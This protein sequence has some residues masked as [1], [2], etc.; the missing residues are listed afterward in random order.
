M[1][2]EAALEL[3]RRRRARQSLLA[4]TQYTK[5][6][7]QPSGHHKI[8]CDALERVERGEIDRLIIEA[9]PRH[10]KSE[11]ATRRFPAWYLGRNSSKQIITASYGKDLSTD[12]GRDVR[13]IVSSLEFQKLF[14]VQLREDVAAASKWHT[15]NGGIYNAVA[16]G[17]AVTGKGAHCLIIDDPIKNREEADSETIREKVWRWYTST[18]YT[19]LMPGGSII[20]ILTRWH[21]DDLAGR[22]LE[23]QQQGQGDKWHHIKLPAIENEHTDH[24]KALW[25]QWY[26][27]EA[28]HRIRQQLTIGNCRDWYSLYQQTPTQEQGTYFQREWFKMY[29]PDELPKDLHKYGAS[30]YAVSEGEGDFTEHGVFGLCPRMDLWV[31]DWWFAQAAADKWIESKLDLWTKHKPFAWF[32]EGGVIQKSV[33]PMLALRIRER[34]AYCRM[35]WL[36]SIHDKTIRARAFQAFAASGRVHIPNT[37]VGKRLVEQLM[38]F[39][40]G[41][42]DDAVDV[43]SLFGRAIDTT[44]PAIVQRSQPQDYDRWRSLSKRQHKEGAESWRTA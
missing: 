12:F 6:D 13:D 23:Q 18:A 30:D 37:V 10:T 29:E 14:P 4:F 7:F 22:L 36:S 27:L 42:H 40:Q 39:P 34:R 32:G 21:E 33:E 17:S 35:E 41:K 43:C 44:H 3:L 16:V 11:L 20:L 28:L 31:L 2:A 19:R 26:P 24:E 15:N 9:P 38:K 25:P 5:P 1:T 8:I